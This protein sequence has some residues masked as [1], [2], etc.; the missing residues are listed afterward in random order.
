MDLESLEQDDHRYLWHPF[1]Q[2]RDWVAEQPLIVEKAEGSYLI[3]VEGNRYLDG[4]SS[5]WVTVHGHQRKELGQAIVHQ[6]GELAHSTFLGL[7]HPPG[8]ILARRLVE[9][10][11]E[12]LQRVFYSDTGAA[13]VEVALKMAFQYWQ[14]RSDPRPT[15]TKF[16][17][18][19]NGYHGDTVG[20]M[21]VGG[22]DLFQRTYSPLLFPTVKAPSAYCYRCYLGKEYPSCGIA[23]LEDVEEALSQHSD[24]L[25]AVIIEPLMQGAGG[26]IALP[27]GYTRS[28]WEMAKKHDVLF[29]ADEV[30]TGF[31]RTGKMFAC[32]REGI[33]PDLM[34][35]GKGVTG[36]YLPLAA[37]LA[38]EEIFSAFLG[39]PEE[40]RT[41][42]H[43]HTYS[44]N[45]LACAAAIANLDIFERDGT[46]DQLQPKIQAL[47][48]GLSRFA[49]LEH[50]GDV[51]QVGFMAG[52]EL[53]QDIHTKQQYSQKDRIGSQIV[54]A[55]RR[56]GVIIRPLGD[57]IV[58]MPP[59][60]ISPSELTFLLDAVYDS[61]KEVTQGE[62]CDATHG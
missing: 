50:V 43:G 59:L 2:M 5:L 24:E 4:I 28:V 30:A 14:Q 55:A 40:E 21:S 1:T 39:T 44:G 51:R 56:R 33:K 11:P 22:I 9:L 23:C 60:S 37:T 18:L 61:I 17:S 35:I 31:G 6:L 46:L 47:V 58:L 32:E 41:F 3:D 52:I 54:H 25:A 27:S 26:M 48:D 8:I 34:T 13:A 10:A 20:A 29:I 7:S 15:R 49:K 57:V 19:L 12:G 42:Y 53:V 38:T 62:C 45:P 36:G 16:L